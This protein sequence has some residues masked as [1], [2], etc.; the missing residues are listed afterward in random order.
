MAKKTVKKVTK[1][2]AL[3]PKKKPLVASKAKVKAKTVRKRQAAP[4]SAPGAAVSAPEVQLDEVQTV[5]VETVPCRYCGQQM[6]KPE[7]GA[8][9]HCGTCEGTGDPDYLKTQEVQ[10][11]YKV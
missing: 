2:K 5:P 10:P 3:A 9:F 8:F 7:T 11:E 4:K 6:P 1:K